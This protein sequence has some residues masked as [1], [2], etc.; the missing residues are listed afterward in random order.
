MSPMFYRP[1]QISSSGKCV[2]SDRRQRDVPSEG[3]MLDVARQQRE[4]TGATRVSTYVCDRP[5]A[6]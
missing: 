5:P 6:S 1:E 3:E 2:E 4:R